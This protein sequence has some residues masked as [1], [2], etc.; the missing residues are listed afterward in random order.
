M[1]AKY[2]SANGSAWRYNA[3]S[4]ISNNSANSSNSETLAIAY[5]HNGSIMLHGVSA[6]VASASAAW[7]QRKAIN[8]NM[9]RASRRG[10]VNNN[11]KRV[12][13]RAQLFCV[14]GGG[15]SARGKSN[16]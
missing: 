8:G 13:I 15:S 10:G 6:T 12:R 14:C 1:A 4:R 3:A 2:Q 11:A 16:I 7:H 5:G 9:L